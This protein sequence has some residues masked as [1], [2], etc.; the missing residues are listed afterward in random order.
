MKDNSII[1]LKRLYRPF[2]RTTVQHRTGRRMISMIGGRKPRVFAG[3]VRG[4]RSE[5][6]IFKSL[7][8]VS[9]GASLP[10]PAEMNRREQAEALQKEFSKSKDKFPIPKKDDGRFKL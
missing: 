9:L 8:G 10:S 2:D 1:F 7:P 6:G 4:D 3:V 5:P